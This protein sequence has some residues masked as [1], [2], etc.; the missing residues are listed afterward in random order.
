MGINPCV[1]NFGEYREVVE[2]RDAVV[3]QEALVLHLTSCHPCPPAVEQR[4]NKAPIYL[5]QLTPPDIVVASKSTTAQ[6]PDG[7]GPWSPQFAIDAVSLSLRDFQSKEWFRNQWENEGRGFHDIKVDQGREALHNLNAW[8]TKQV[9]DPS[10]RGARYEDVTWP[11]PSEQ[12]IRYELTRLQNF[13]NADNHYAPVPDWRLAPGLDLQRVTKQ[14]V[15]ISDDPEPHA[16]NPPLRLLY[17]P[18]ETLSEGTREALADQVL[19]TTG[20][21]SFERLY[22]RT[23]P[24]DSDSLSRPQLPGRRAKTTIVDTSSEENRILAK[25]KGKRKS[26]QQWKPLSGLWLAF[27]RSVAKSN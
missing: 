15:P 9:W 26:A 6:L 21:T 11:Q 23:Q 4:C 22:E 18:A 7:T 14:L 2:V 27:L 8:A 12:E 25:G 3:Q 24:G 16:S 20:E 5:G 10:A 1:D 13:A 19:Q 17:D